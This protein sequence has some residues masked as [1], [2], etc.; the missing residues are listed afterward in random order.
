VTNKFN[1][2]TVTALTVVTAIA[3][4]ISPA[5]ADSEPTPDNL[6]MADVINLSTAY[7]SSSSQAIMQAGR[8]NVIQDGHHVCSKLDAG[9][10]VKEIVNSAVEQ[11]MQSGMSR[12]EFS[13]VWNPYFS[14]VLVSAINHYCPQHSNLLQ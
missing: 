3:S 6:F 10:S 11:M 1:Q 7:S 5:K 13:E 9:Y 2:L 8:A 12:Q 14:A 4:V